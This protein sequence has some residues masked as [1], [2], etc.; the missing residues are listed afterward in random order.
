MTSC[1]P[2]NGSCGIGK[3]TRKMGC[4]DMWGLEVSSEMC[5]LHP[6]AVAPPSILDCYVPCSEDCVVSGWSEW[7]PCPYTCKQGRKMS[8][9][10]RR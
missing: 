10:Q 4:Y 3:I 7:T 8:G 1:Q 2:I 5:Y 6:L 9:R